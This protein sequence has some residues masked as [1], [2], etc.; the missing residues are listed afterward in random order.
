M[1]ASSDLLLLH[2]ALG[3]SAQL[4]PL[5]EVLGSRYRVHLLDFEGHGD[6]PPRDRPFRVSHFG[7]NVIE[8]L[9][10][11]GVERAHVFGY[12]MGGYVALHL[13]AARPGRLGDVATLGT[14]FAWTPDVAAREAGRLDPA[15]IRAKVPRFAD[16]LAA[17]HANA[18][19]WE[20]VLARTAELLRELGDRPAVDAGGLS[21]VG[22]RVRIMVGDRDATTSVEESAAAYRNLPA[23]EL[24]VLPRTPHPLEQVDCGM[25]A[26]TLA[27]YFG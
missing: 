4:A 22:Q 25:L 8:Y 2:G 27:D 16:A 6:R 23:G 26:R 7:E 3:A 5:A 1:S 9:D 10:E 21:R 12:S 13:A 15:A 24:A 17:R 14:K 11:R 19:G 18:G 20:G